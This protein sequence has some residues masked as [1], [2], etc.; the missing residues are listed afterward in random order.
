MI[1]AVTGSPSSS[2]PVSAIRTV[3]GISNPDTPSRCLRTASRVF[4]MPP[5]NSR[6]ANSG[7]HRIGSTFLGRR[8]AGA[9]FDDFAEMIYANH[10]GT[11]VL[12]QDP[13]CGHHLLEAQPYRCLRRWRILPL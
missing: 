13:Q 2:V 8:T 4:L 1:G 10:Q 11:C 6:S 12:G 5:L 9:G 3:K 7:D